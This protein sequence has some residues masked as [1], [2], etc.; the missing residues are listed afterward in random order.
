MKKGIIGIA[1][2]FLTVTALLAV[3]CSSATLITSSSTTTLPPTT[4]SQTIITSTAAA[5]VPTSTTSVPASTIN[6]TTTSTGNWWDSLGTP[7]YGGSLTLVANQDPVYFDPY[8]GEANASIIAAWMQ[9]LFGPDWTVDPSAFNFQMEFIPDEYNEGTLAQSWEFTNP[10]TFV[11][12]LRQNVYWQ[13][14]TP[15]NGRQFV[16]SDVVDHYDRQAG[17]GGMPADPNYTA[18]DNPGLLSVV[19]T[20]NYIVTFNYSITNPE[21]I[22]EALQAMAGNGVDIENPESVA[23]WGNLNDWHHAIGTGPFILT[24]F[25]DNSEATMARNPNYWGY[26]ERNPQNQLPYVNQI[27]ALVIPNT[28]TAEAAL[29]VGKI[30]LMA[31]VSALDA[32]GIGKTNPQISQVLVP[33]S[34]SDSIDMVNNV[35]PFTNI[36][37]RIAM[38][39]AINLPQIANTYFDGTCS[40]DPSG[41]I[42]NDM[43]GWGFPYNQWPASLQA[44]YAY[45]PTNAKALLA[46]AGYPNGFNTNITVESTCDMG[47]VQIVQSELASIGVNASLTVMVPAAWTSY[48]FA[49]RSCTQ[50]GM[51]GGGVIG[52]TWQPSRGI[53]VFENTFITDYENV[54]DPSY[55][56]LVNEALASTTL[57][58][59][60]QYVASVCEYAEEQQYVVSLIHPT[61]YDLCQPNIKGFSGQYDS[62]PAGSGTSEVQY[63]GFYCSRFWI[64]QN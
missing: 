39:E 23:L 46:A 9:S 20:G 24:D 64:G 6:E 51:R 49:T 8:Q 62:I 54:N 55:Q 52:A 47:L 22:L 48:C 7:Q 14:I 63:L 36:N 59:M 4:S 12:N 56:N 2:I 31:G 50:M 60:K 15:A 45:N 38:Q 34:G 13:N 32:Q 29:R 40:P 16:A 26:D 18:A 19:A 10:N 28:A 17:L 5:S 21:T 25:V 42:S 43:S 53:L 30:S 11:V 58:Q 44:Q 57:D 33:Q 61:A 35:K 41:M 1:L 3:S 37:V 27:N